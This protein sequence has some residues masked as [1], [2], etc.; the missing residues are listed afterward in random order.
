MI[1]ASY[2]DASVS[3]IEE[4]A[5]LQ[6]FLL[7]EGNHFVPRL[8]YN[9]KFKTGKGPSIGEWAAWI[10]AHTGRLICVYFDYI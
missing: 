1:L 9:P 5:Q 2:F 10:D 3:S 7:P 8:I 6:F 4:N